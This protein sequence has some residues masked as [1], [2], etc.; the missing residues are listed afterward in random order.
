MVEGYHQ[1]EAIDEAVAEEGEDV[2]V[3][4]D[5][6]A[7]APMARSSMEWNAKTS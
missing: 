5:E 2:V 6:A 7:G 4:E 1:L 3:A